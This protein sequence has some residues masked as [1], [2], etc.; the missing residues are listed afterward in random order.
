MFTT[1][2][3][4]EVT[5]LI[6]ID[7]QDLEPW[8]GALPSRE[9]IADGIIRLVGDDAQVEIKWVQLHADPA[10]PDLRASVTFVLR[11]EDFCNVPPTVSDIGCRQACC[12]TN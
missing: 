10:F 5:D 1:R 12:Q 11:W 3:S 2:H 4:H 9:E 6:R 8:G 7:A